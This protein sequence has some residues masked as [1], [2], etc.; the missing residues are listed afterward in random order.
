MQEIKFSVM[1]NESYP[2]QTAERFAPV[3][4][5]FEQQTHIRVN[6][7]VIPWHT[8][9]S[10]IIKYGLYG[11]G[12]DVSELG[13]TWIASLASMG[14]LRPFTPSE[15]ASLGGPE[16]FFPGGWDV[17][18][19]PGDPKAWG[20]PWLADTLVVYYWK[21]T[22]AEAGI[23]DAQDAFSTPEKMQQTLKQ[24]QQHGIQ[25]PLAMLLQSSHR[26]MHQAVN[27]VWN[28][29]GDLLS[30]DGKQIT[31]ADEAS[32]RGLHNYF[33][34]LPYIEPGMRSND[35]NHVELFTNKKVA[36]MID[37]LRYDVIGRRND[38]NW[39]EK[40][41]IANLFRNVWVGGM[42]FGIWKHSRRSA[43]CIEWIRFL[44]NQ[45][46]TSPVQ[47][48]EVM[49]YAQRE[50]FTHSPDQ[51]PLYY[52]TCEQALKWGRG[53][54]SAKGWGSIEE[55]LEKAVKNAWEFLQANPTATP[56]DAIRE[57][58]EPLVRR[59]NLTIGE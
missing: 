54:P 11:Q 45:A 58:I 22:L 47:L 33:N 31:F 59:L 24:L 50:S 23:G 51:E 49:L 38:P 28:S 30:P 19:L 10:Q 40:I 34:L 29:G 17:N 35:A 53:F 15:V 14:A 41:G 18:F 42:N 21:D 1:S 2:G 37:G 32:T 56:Q 44:H 13:T 55:K 25:Y 20:I 46:A 12:P 43:E 5:A 8:G 9:W 4:D 52:Q 57:Q 3:L 16:A 39:R 7:T 6:L 27:W 36:V 26:I 48:H